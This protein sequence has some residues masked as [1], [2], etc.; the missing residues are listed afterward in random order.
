MFHSVPL[1]LRADWR[2][3]MGSD[4]TYIVADARYIPF[5]AGSLDAAFSYA[6][7]QHLAKDDARTV[8][9][10]IARVLKPGGT[11]DLCII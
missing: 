7:C 6:F 5:P 10:G 3:R 8:F 4:A 2:S 1:P 9:G 11:I